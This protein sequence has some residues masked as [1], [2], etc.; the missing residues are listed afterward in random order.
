MKIAILVWGFPPKR[1]AG[2]EIAAYNIARHLARKGYKVHVI[3]SLDEGLPKESVEQGFHVHRVGFPKIKFLGIAIFRLKVLLTLR[4]VN[5]DTVHGH[6]TGISLSGFLAKKVLGKPYLV[7]RRG[8]DIGLGGLF[9]R[10]LSRLVLKNADAV[11]ALTEDMKR[12]IQ[13]VINREVF[14][15]PNGIDFERFQNLSRDKIR[16]KLQARVDE[17]LVVFVGRFRPE[18][19]VR[20][21]IEAMEIIR[22]KSQNA[23]LILVGEGPEEEDLKRLVEQLNLRDCVDFL[24]QVPNEEVPQYMAAS[25]VFVLPSLAEGFPNVILEAMASGLAIVACRVSG[26]PEIV[27]D[28]GNGFLVESKNPEQIAEKVLLLLGNDELRERISKN[29]KEKAK[30]YSWESVVE[31]LEEVYLKTSRK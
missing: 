14:V 3:T 29:N 27:E 4:R 31:R 20:Y 17:R 6:G 5:P 11:I 1:L 18:K 12:E 16:Y 19:G 15:I 26:L 13:T 21:L 9:T 30:G 7:W 2:A 24:G 23:R 28:G 8:I 25:D 22:R 10:T